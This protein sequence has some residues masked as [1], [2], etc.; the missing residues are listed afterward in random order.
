MAMIIF[1]AILSDLT[2]RAVS[3]LIDKC[4]SLTAAAPVEEALNNL[5]RLLH[6]VHVI[7]E[8]SQQRIVTNQAMLRQLDRL[9]KEMY[10]GYRVLDAL[11]FREEPEDDDDPKQA[12]VSPSFSTS[13][14][15][16]AKR[17]RLLRRG[18]SSSSSS[19]YE[20]VTE[21]LAN[22]EIAIG[23]V[24]KLV[25]HLSRCPR[26]CRQPYS[27]HLLLDKCMFSRQ[28]EMDQVLSFLLRADTTGESETPAV[29]PIIGTGR[30]GKTT[31]IE[32]A[33]NDERVR[34]HFSQ[35][36]RYS[37]DSIR[38]VKTVPTLSNCALIKSHDHDHA[39]VGGEK[40][41]VI[42]E[43]TGDINEDVW[44]K[45]YSDCRHQIA[46]GSKIIVASRSD[47]VARLGTTQPLA[48]RPFTQEAYWYFFKVRTFG[49]TDLKDHPRVASMAMDLAWE[50]NG[51][52]FG[53]SVFSRLLE[54]NFDAKSWSMALAVAREF[55]RV[56]LLL[57]R[58]DFVDLWQVVDPV[59][60]RRAS[61]SP[62]S[63]YIVI[64]DDYQMAGS[65]QSEEGPQMM[66]VRDLLFGN[67]STVVP[68]G[69]F[70]VLAWRSH[71]PPHYSYMMTCEVR[72]PWW[73][74]P[75]KKRVQQT[76]R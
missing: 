51:C 13:M 39:L 30:V 20:R 76:G 60:V 61:S 38:D 8:E 72:R 44:L 31:I 49:S 3:F 40:T 66:S 53:A 50:M 23:D 55:K 4:S 7:V 10:R 9:Q 14:F 41:L 59:F 58:E 52:F 12:V 45:L 71:I 28:M 75:R 48:V 26:L 16:P 69:R 17:L 18:G 6:R 34:S 67:S 74:L 27:M 46:S 56:N 2:S 15:N 54:G 1:S 57:F 25:V 73:M 43:L 36:L 19:D 64:L 11:R 24:S 29:L 37:Q 32:H 42:I 5:Q 63:Q 33:C 22:L 21:V 47:K 62:S 35:I 70:K 68:H 65:T